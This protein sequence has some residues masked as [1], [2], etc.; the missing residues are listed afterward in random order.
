MWELALRLPPW[1]PQS[2]VDL[3]RLARHGLEMTQ[4]LRT[5]SLRTQKLLFDALRPVSSHLGGQDD[6]LRLFVD[7][8]LLISA[9]ATSADTNALYGASALDLPRRGVVH[10]PGGIGSIAETLAQSVRSNGGQV[11]YRREATQ[12][13]F[14]GGKVSAVETR[15]GEHYPADLVIANLPPLNIARLIPETRGPELERLARRLRKLHPP[16]GWGAF[17][18]YA[19]IDAGQIPPDLPLHQQVVVQEPLAEANSIFL[20]L[21]PAF[22]PGRAPQDQRAVTMS[23][24]TRLSPWWRAFEQDRSRYEAL[25]SETCERMLAAAEVAI[26]GFR[27]AATL[28]LPGTPVTFQRFTRRVRGWVGGYPQTSLF[29]ANAPALTPGLWMVGDS[30]FPGQSIPAVALGGLRVA[31]DVLMNIR[32]IEHENWNRWEWFGRLDRGICDGHA[33]RWA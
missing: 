8:Q 9:Q 5:Q 29:R 16:D 10:L 4:K 13:L 1:P 7:A 31:R 33:R 19:G 30:V 25:K 15:Q 6:L 17:V 2:M 14:Q 20:S 23:T 12:V 21:S 28:I 32:S 18:V 11:L 27:Q 24:H 3:A 22:D 26:P